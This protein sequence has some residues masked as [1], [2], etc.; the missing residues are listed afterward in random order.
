[1]QDVPDF[2]HLSTGPHIRT[3]PSS[4]AD[5]SIVGSFEF[6]LTQFTVLV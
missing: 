2:E 5:A 4:L 6:Q 3:V 1:M